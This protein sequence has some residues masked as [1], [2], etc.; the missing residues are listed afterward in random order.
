M[1]QPNEGAWSDASK[2]EQAL[3]A[4]LPD[5]AI[6]SEPEPGTLTTTKAM[7]RIYIWLGTK[8]Y[9]G[10]GRDRTKALSAA[11]SKVAES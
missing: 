11:V 3:L 2:D 8:R 7:V 5:N 1:T 4:A 10:A 6:V 9:M